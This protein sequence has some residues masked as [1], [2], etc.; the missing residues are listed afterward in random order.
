MKVEIQGERNNYKRY[1][2]I[3]KDTKH[4]STE[5]DNDLKQKIGS[6]VFAILLAACTVLSACGNESGNQ[7]VGQTDKSETND[8]VQEGEEPYTIVYAF[9]VWVQQADW[10]LVE[11][12]LS[13][14]VYD[15]IGAKVKLLPMTGA[16]YQQEVNLMITSGE[17]L[18]LVNA[19]ARNTFSSDV[20][21]NKL[22]GLDEET[23]RKYAPDAMEVIG[24]YMEATTVDGKIY[25]FPTIRDM[26]SAYGLILRNDIIEKYGIDADAGLTVEQLDDLFARIK[27]GEP[28][29]YVTQPQSQGTSILESLFKTYDGLG[30][31]MGVLMDWGQGD[32]TVQNLFDTEY[33]EECVRKAREWNE[34]GYILPDAS[35]NPDTG[36]A[37]FKTGKVA[38]TMSLIHPG[39][40]TDSTNMTGIPCSTAIVNPAFGNTQTVGAVIQSIP[41]SCKNPEKVLEFVNL[42]YSDAEVYNA[43][44]WG[45]EGTHYQHVKGSEKWITYPDGVTGETSG[46]TLSA[47]YAFGNRYLSYIWNT[48]PEDLNEKYEEFNDNAIKSKAL[49]FVFDTTPVKAE[50]A[51]VQ[52]VMDEY[53]LPLEN[54]VIDPDENLPKFRQALKDA[55]IDTVIAEKQRQLDEWAATK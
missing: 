27:E 14:I 46:Y 36:V 20:T 26:A 13:N 6:K 9:D 53:R 50:A 15:K 17:K 30:D 25:G 19:S 39:V 47:T 48:D 33:Y 34:K 8:T 42:L 31:T 51:A 32:L 35:T 45:I 43:L 16:N 4:T 7:S 29:K 49:G 2:L 55:G 23:V 40:P 18:D 11:E 52:A 28:D 1:S 38:S 44:V 22:L 5:G 24:D 41:V 37:Y 54:G 21:S 10:D 3:T 12:N